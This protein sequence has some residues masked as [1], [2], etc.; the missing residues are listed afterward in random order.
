MEYYQENKQQNSIRISEAFLFLPRT[1]L[2][3]FSV[4]PALLFIIY[5]LAEFLRPCFPNYFLGN[6]NTTESL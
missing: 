4:S 3:Q 5:S 1:V 6:Y 2:V